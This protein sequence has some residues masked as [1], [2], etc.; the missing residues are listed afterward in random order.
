MQKIMK[1]MTMHKASHPR[2][3]IDRPYVKNRRHKKNHQHW[4]L[5]RSNTW[6]TGGVHKKSEERLITTV[7]S[8]NVNL[9][10]HSKITKSRKQFER[11]IMVW[12]LQITNWGDGARDY[13]DMASSSSSCRVACTDLPWPSRHP[14]PSYIA[15]RRS[16]WLYP[17]SAQSGCI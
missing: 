10:T 16:S 4:G 13:L 5:R 9:G 12:I 7:S 2:N 3:N 17:V 1:L 6:K 8:C 11:K 15:L 14:S